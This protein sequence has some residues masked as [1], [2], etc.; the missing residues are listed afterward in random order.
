MLAQ[1]S[2][3]SEKENRERDFHGMGGAGG[4]KGE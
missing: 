4:W 3:R 1:N 2:I